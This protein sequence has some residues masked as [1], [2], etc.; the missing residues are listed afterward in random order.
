MAKSQLYTELVELLT[1]GYQ[2]DEEDLH[3]H[4]TMAKKIEKLFLKAQPKADKAD[5]KPAKATKAKAD[6]AEKPEKPKKKRPASVYANVTGL[7]AALYGTKAEM[8]EDLAETEITIVT[9]AFAKDGTPTEEHYQEL[10][11]AFPAGKKMSLLELATAVR[12]AM[13]VDEKKPNVMSAASV[14]RAM[15]SVEQQNELSAEFKEL[16][17]VSE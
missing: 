16:H 10:K 7:V 13:T 11:A 2:L 5:T 4:D 17:V 9:P 12:E 14:V 8:Y 15:I 1:V 3:Q 6:K